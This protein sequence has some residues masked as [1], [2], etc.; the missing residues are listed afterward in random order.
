MEAQQKAMPCNAIAQTNIL[1]LDI[2]FISKF[3]I[4]F[5]TQQNTWDGTISY[6]SWRINNKFNQKRISTVAWHVI[7]I[8]IISC[9]IATKESMMQDKI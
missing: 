1:H 6:N 8:Q 5:S 9:M 3:H 4:L 7:L 2:F